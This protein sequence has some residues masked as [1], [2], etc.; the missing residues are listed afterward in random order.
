MIEPIRLNDD[1][2]DTDVKNENSLNCHFLPLPYTIQDA[3]KLMETNSSFIGGLLTPPINVNS[4]DGYAYILP[5][6]LLP[7]FVSSG[8]QFEHLTENTDILTLDIRS[9]YRS[10]DI[11]STMIQLEI[12]HL[13]RDGN[14]S[15]DDL[16]TEDVYHIG[17]GYWSDGFDVG[18]ASKAKRSLVK[19]VTIHVIHPTLTENHVFPVGFGSNKGDHKYV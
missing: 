6:C 7:I 14:S 9:R 15:C 19:L 12:E 4:S 17:L 11:Y 16:D 1:N 5:S 10:P 8:L 18:S 13:N 3:R 2:I